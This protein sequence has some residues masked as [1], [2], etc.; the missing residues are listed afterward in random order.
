MI[1][2]TEIRFFITFCRDYRQYLYY[3]TLQASFKKFLEETGNL[4]QFTARFFSSGIKPRYENR[5]LLNQCYSIGYL[6]LPLVALTSFIMELVIT[7]LIFAGKLGSSIGAELGSMKM[8]EQI[9]A[10][11]VSH[12]KPVK[13]LVAT[14]IMATTLMLPLF[15]IIGDSISLFSAYLAC[16]K[17]KTIAKWNFTKY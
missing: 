12:I 1:R 13:Y 3:M 7:A 2:V 9:D 15:T 5:E 17:Y 4:S 11:T 14:R 8:T 6:S 16:I 10:T